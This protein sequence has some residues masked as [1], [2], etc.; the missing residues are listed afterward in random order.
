MDLIKSIKETLGGFDMK[1]E[2]LEEMVRDKNVFV[3]GAG[4][5]GDIAG[6]YFLA[7]KID[8]MG[9]NALI[10]SVVWERYSV[11]PYPG[12]IPIETMIDVEPIGYS[13]AIV[14]PDSYALR[15]GKELIPQLV[16]L[17][18]ATKGRAIF[19]D[20]T[21]GVEGVRKAIEDVVS[22]FG[23]EVAIAVDVGG[24]ILALGCE[25]G[26]QSPLAD[27]ISLSALYSSGIDS[28]VAVFGI[29]AD[30]E[31]STNTLLSYISEIARKGGLIGIY[32]M[33]RREALS[34]ENIV[35]EVETEASLMPLLS[36]KGEYGE[37][38]IRNRTRVVRLSPILALSFIFDTEAVYNRSLLPALVKESQGIG[39]AN[40][41]LN[42][43]CLYTELDLEND[44]MRI[45]SKSS[46]K[47]ISVTQI[48]QEG[49]SRLVKGGCRPIKC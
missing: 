11:D 3:F 37:R 44:L 19:I 9:G 20:I 45:R 29:S 47:P 7:R 23:I 38:Y 8:D 39:N 13:S 34:Y 26:L 31:L 12:P 42:E 25:E 28:A 48:R 41:A 17:V 16:R 6:S 24:D 33:S 2:S 15:Y 22:Y 43:R 14:N 40:Q 49:I 4:G 32:G 36:F 27:S 5:G 35:K 30:G 46:E 21:K 1:Y 10:G 18:K